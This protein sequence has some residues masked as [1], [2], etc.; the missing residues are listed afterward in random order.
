MIKIPQY[1]PATAPTTSLFLLLSK[2]M[3]KKRKREKVL[4]QLMVYYCIDVGV[5]EIE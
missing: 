1:T 2:H 5:G 4:I 3:H